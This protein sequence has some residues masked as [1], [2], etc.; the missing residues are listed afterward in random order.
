MSIFAISDLH[1]SFT[2]KVVLADEQAMTAAIAKPMDIFGWGKHYLKLKENWLRVVTEKD[3]V[4]MPGDT[5]WAL[6]LEQ[7]MCDFDW[8]A[9]LPGKKVISPGNHCYFA[10]SKKKI[11]DALPKSIEWLDAEAT[12]VEEKVVVATRG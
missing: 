7:A 5:S 3:T 4:L 8:I 2:K 12:L 6:R 10:R 11:R 1:L 9:Q